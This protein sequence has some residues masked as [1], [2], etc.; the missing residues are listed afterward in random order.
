MPRRLSLI[1]A[2][3]SV[4]GGLTRVLPRAEEIAAEVMQVFVANPRG[5]APPVLDPIGDAAFAAA[6]AVPSS[7]TRRT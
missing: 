6:C 7:S 5:W 3:V 4:A 2:H 1:G